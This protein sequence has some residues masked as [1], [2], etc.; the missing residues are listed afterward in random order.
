M[1][2][3]FYRH[4]A[5][6]LSKFNRNRWL[7]VVEYVMELVKVGGGAELTKSA[8]HALITTMFECLIDT[9][10][11]H[12]AKYPDRIINNV[13]NLSDAVDESFPGY[14]STGLLGKLLGEREACV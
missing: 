3:P 13:V 12:E 8:K 5:S 14:L 1:K 2:R 6:A 9:M 7:D 11:K 4:R 10:S